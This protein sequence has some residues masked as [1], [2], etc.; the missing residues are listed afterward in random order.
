MLGSPLK[1]H[2]PGVQGLGWRAQV[3][4][5]PNVAATSMYDNWVYHGGCFRLSF[6]FGWGVRS[7]YRPT[8][9]W[10]GCPL[11]IARGGGG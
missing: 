1:D 9:L 8:R 5:K 2:G 11:M 6:N 4:M 7:L 10:L 3:C